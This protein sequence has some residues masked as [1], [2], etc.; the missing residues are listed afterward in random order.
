[1]SGKVPI[2][3]IAGILR[4]GMGIQR[5]GEALGE[6]NGAPIFR[7]D[8]ADQPV[9]L[10]GA[11]GPISQ[12]ESSFEGVPLALGFDVDLPPKLGLREAR[13]LIDL[14]L[15][16]PVPGLRKLH[17]QG[18]DTAEPPE[19]D[20]LAEGAPGGLD[21]ERSAHESGSIRC[22][23][24]GESGP[25][26]KRGLAQTKTFGDDDRNSRHSVQVTWPRVSIVGYCQLS[27]MARQVEAN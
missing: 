23:E 7:A 17:G 5:C 3:E 20:P 8:I 4:L 15:P 26:G 21:E 2:D 13:A 18:T 25:V 11:D 12:R 24:L 16:D 22:H 9:H 1:M 19:C 6:P 10:A 14:D 27:A